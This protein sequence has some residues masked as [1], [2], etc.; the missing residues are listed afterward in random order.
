MFFTASRIAP[1]AATPYKGSTRASFQWPRCL[2]FLTSPFSPQYIKRLL[3]F[4]SRPQRATIRRSSRDMHDLRRLLKYLRPHLGTFAIATLAM[5][6]V[7]LLESAI[8]AL[9]VPIADQAAGSGNS[10]QTSTLF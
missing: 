8:R 7:G 6:F 3:E 2:I 10:G 1:P 4:A 5:I 9:I